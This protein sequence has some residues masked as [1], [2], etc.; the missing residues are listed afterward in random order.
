MR[1]QGR[2]GREGHTGAVATLQLMHALQHGQPP[3]QW[4]ARSH[5]RRPQV[6]AMKP[7]GKAVAVMPG[8]CEI[9]EAEE[10]FSN[11]SPHFL[12]GFG[13]K[14]DRHKTEGRCMW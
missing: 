12:P 7:A 1:K 9:V 6:T 13:A 3:T 2:S 5:R 8:D 10:N 14:S 11:R 4:K